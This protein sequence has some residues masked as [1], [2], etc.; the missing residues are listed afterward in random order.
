[1]K[2]KSIQLFSA[3][4]DGTLL[5]IKSSTER[6]VT[7][8]NRLDPTRRPWLVYNTG[9]RIDDVQ[10][11]VARGV[12]PVADVIIGGVGTELHV[13][14][15]PQLADEFRSRFGKNWDLAKVERIVAEH[16]NVTR[17]P[18]EFLHPYKSSWIWP[19]AAPSARLEL[20]KKLRT[21]GISAVIVYSSDRFLD[22]LPECG[23]K[24]Q[25]LHWLCQRLGIPFERV[26][27]AGDTGNDS[28]MFRLEG[29]HR[30]LVGN[31]LPELL[32]DCLG[33]PKYE[34]RRIM[35]DGVLEGLLHFGVI[36]Q[37][38]VEPKTD[39]SDRPFFLNYRTKE[40]P[41]EP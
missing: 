33:Y 30:V 22:V 12:L 25:A 28:S 32:A 17:Q 3:D 34:A 9:R 8:W 37:I 24:G 19:R 4:L 2:T 20:Q 14:A 21:A 31:A 39:E 18:P 1:M 29:V 23:N 36:E 13:A 5:G 7:V 6:F 26:L 41:I 27:V 35:A 11:L 15:N 16:P 38:P 10:N 40:E